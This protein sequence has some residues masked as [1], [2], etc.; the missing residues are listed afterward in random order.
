MARIA[1]IIVLVAAVAVAASGFGEIVKVTTPRAPVYTGQKWVPLP[2]K[3]EGRRFMVYGARP[4]L[5]FIQLSAKKQ[6]YGWIRAQDVEV[7]WGKTK[8]VRVVKVH[9]TN[10]LKL[11]DGEWLKFAGV[12]VPMD[13]TP[14]TRQTLAWLKRLLE[15][16]EVTL[17]YDP[18]VRRNEQDYD[19]AYVYVEGLFVNRAL[20]ERG[21]AKTSYKYK[22]AGGRYHEVFGYF[23]RKA[24]QA[25]IGVWAEEKPAEEPEPGETEEA[26]PVTPEPAQPGSRYVRTLSD[27]E[28]VQWARNLQTEIKAT[29]KRRRSERDLVSEDEFDDDVYETPTETTSVWIKTLEIT[30]KNGWG[31]PL[32][33]LTAKY[34]LFARTGKRFDSVQ[35]HS[36]GEIAG[37]NLKPGET[38]KLASK[39][40]IFETK[41]ERGFVDAPDSWFGQKYYGC[42]VTFY[43]KGTPVKVVAQPA[44]L[45]DFEVPSED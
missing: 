8:R 15:G 26:A 33:G 1:G 5:Y 35:F 13:D 31:F 21:L 19:V 9:D 44:K 14:L 38:R 37:I 16:K 2:A 41:E 34:E 27:A 12:M 18:K 29:G 30:V 17:E 10:T 22:S 4:G 20:V 43:Y 6:T 25:G 24:Q 3:A 39:P 7:D 28:R 40:T 11:S 23:S 45:A 42:R 36:S 32:K